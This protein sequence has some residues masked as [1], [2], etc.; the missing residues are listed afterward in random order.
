MGIAEGVSELLEATVV[1]NGVRIGRI[2]DVILN[3]AGGD[4]VGFEV[5]CED[6]QH[7][8]LP[9][10]AV[11]VADDSTVEIGSPFA[12]LDAGEL[13]FYRRRGVTLRRREEPAA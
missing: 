2:V 10:A 1:F 8:F 7:R 11:T 12:L 4:V 3:R 5:R 6:R 13:E 9:R